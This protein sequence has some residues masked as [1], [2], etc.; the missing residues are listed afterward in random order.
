M[1]KLIFHKLNAFA[2]GG[3][4]NLCEELMFFIIRQGQDRIGPRKK[5][6]ST[7]S[8]QK[9]IVLESPNHVFS[10]GPNFTEISIIFPIAEFSIEPNTQIN[11]YW[12]AC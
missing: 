2:K 7:G 10:G 9:K 5:L 8:F 12:A 1:Y 11:S 4:E 3:M 6:F